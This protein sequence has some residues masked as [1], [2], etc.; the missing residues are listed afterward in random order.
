MQDVLRVILDRARYVNNQIKSV[1]TE[2]AI[3]CIEMAIYRF[4]ERAAIRHKRSAAFYEISFS[5]IVNGD[6][7]CVKCGHVGCPGNCH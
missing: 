6:G 3:N 2:E 5:G 7:K 1:K 4:E